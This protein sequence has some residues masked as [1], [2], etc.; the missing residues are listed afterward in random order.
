MY[1]CADVPIW[2]PPVQA[3]GAHYESP[4]VGHELDDA[5]AILR[6]PLWRLTEDGV[7]FVGDP[8]PDPPGGERALEEL[9]VG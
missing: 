5:P 9:E 7:R 1:E 3:G 2:R 4:A 8:D 6:Y